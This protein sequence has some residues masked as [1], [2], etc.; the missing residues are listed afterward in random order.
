MERV[1]LGVSLRDQIRKEI[2]GRTRV[3]DI[4]QRFAMLKWQWMRLIARRTDG[5]WG[6]KVL[7]WRTVRLGVSL[8]DQIRIEEICGRTRV[9]DIAQRFAMLKWQWMRLIARR[10]DGRWGP[11]VLEWRSVGR[12]LSVSWTDGIK[13]DVYAFFQRLP[14]GKKRSV[15]WILEVQNPPP[16][17]PR[18][19]SSSGPKSVEVMQMIRQMRV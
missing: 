8:R 15:P 1:R 5:R 4:A 6:P 13:L 17:I 18:P 10:T 14:A 9:T 2:C 12:P 16:S 7:E 11:K 19:M 3:T